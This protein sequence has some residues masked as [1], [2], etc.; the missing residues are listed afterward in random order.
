MLQFVNLFFNISFGK[1][2]FNILRAKFLLPYHVCKQVMLSFQ[3]LQTIK[4]F[5]F[6]LCENCQHQ[7]QKKSLKLSFKELQENMGEI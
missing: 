4:S 7:S 3:T 5:I 2:S 1:K 6:V